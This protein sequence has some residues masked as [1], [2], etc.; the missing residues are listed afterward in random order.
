MI[1]L[2][3]AVIQIQVSYSLSLMPVL[4]QRGVGQLQIQM[5]AYG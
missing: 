1:Q 5:A 2:S 4:I 3:S